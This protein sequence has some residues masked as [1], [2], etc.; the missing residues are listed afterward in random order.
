MQYSI[1]V[2]LV[3]LSIAIM[4]FIFYFDNLN[5]KRLVY[6]IFTSLFVQF[7]IIYFNFTLKGSIIYTITLCLILSAAY[8]DIKEK[9]ILNINIYFV[10]A[11]TGLLIIF[12]IVTHMP[13][14]SHIEALLVTLAISI[15]LYKLKALGAGDIPLLTILSYIL[16]DNVIIV[17]VISCVITSVVAITQKII[18]K[19]RSKRIAYAPALLIAFLLFISYINIF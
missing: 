14:T 17:I 15:T 10:Y 2:I 12:D 9:K 1:N 11:V 18:K 16:A 6:S 13:L 19:K 8:T 3:I 5:N 4:N 7:I